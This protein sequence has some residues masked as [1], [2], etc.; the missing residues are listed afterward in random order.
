METDDGFTELL[1]PQRTTIHKYFNED[2]L[3]LSIASSA[4]LFEV[5]QRL[6]TSPS[7]MFDSKVITEF[8]GQ[9]KV[10]KKGYDHTLGRIN[11]CTYT[12]NS[13]Y[14]ASDDEVVRAIL[15]AVPKRR[16]MLIQAAFR[17]DRFTIISKIVPLLKALPNYPIQLVANIIHG[18][19]V[20]YALL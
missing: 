15:E 5:F 10:G 11:Q 8:V 19:Y 16:S 7:T 4:G 12:N 2:Q 1:T 9:R 13:E 17:S 6:L 3:A 18:W 20:T 14:C